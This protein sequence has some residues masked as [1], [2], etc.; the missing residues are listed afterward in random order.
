M[1]P[2]ADARSAT[3]PEECGSFS[4]GLAEFAGHFNASD[5]Q[6]Y[7]RWAGPAGLSYWV[8]C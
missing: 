5:G 3:L 4:Y 2:P 8:V 1:P 7:H 6:H